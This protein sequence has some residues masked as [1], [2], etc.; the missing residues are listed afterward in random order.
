MTRVANRLPRTDVAG[1]AI[2]VA[3]VIS[4]CA[5]T[6]KSTKTVV[7]EV[8]SAEG[9]WRGKALVNNWRTK[10]KA[11]LDLD[12]LAREPS[13][14]RMEITGSFGVHVASIA[15]NGNRVSSILTQEKRFIDGPASA[16]TLVRVV[17]IRIPPD[18]L[19]ALL[20]ERELPKDEWTC[21]YD[22]VTKL[23]VFCTHRGGDVAIKW[24]EREGRN[25]RLK[26]T[27]K[28]ADIEMT[29]D[30]AKSKVEFNDSAFQLV[31]PA[32]YKQE[33]LDSVQP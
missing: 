23:A 32:G 1:A 22:R 14:L 4:G 10:Q 9:Q 31:S 12:V 30:Q 33:H 15:L 18:A 13:W 17:P 25:R 8:G 26:I 27:A 28:E 21:D 16:D 5:G 11:Y 2:V 3:A 19:L 7:G 24:L 29:L 20:F 6:P